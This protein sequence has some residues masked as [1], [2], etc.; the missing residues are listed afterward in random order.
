MMPPGGDERIELMR[1]VKELEEQL[2]QRTSNVLQNAELVNEFKLYKQ[3][4]NDARARRSTGRETGGGAT[5][6]SVKRKD[7]KAHALNTLQ[8][9]GGG[10]I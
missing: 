3:G 1:R 5:T 2:V 8:H 7:A 9:G 6:G 10:S 4:V